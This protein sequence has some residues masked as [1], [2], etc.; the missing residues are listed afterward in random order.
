[1]ITSESPLSEN[2]VLGS[3]LDL[4]RL[5]F[6]TA[7]HLGSAANVQNVALCADAKATCI[8]ISEPPTASVDYTP[9]SSAQY[10][11]TPSIS[12]KS[13]LGCLLPR[14]LNDSDG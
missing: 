14:P 3:Y 1:M 11:H 10:I 6:F 8:A 2:A 9:A 4:E 5:F 7:P 12:A 13:S